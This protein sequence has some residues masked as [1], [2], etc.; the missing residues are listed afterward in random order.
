MTTPRPA[1]GMAGG[2]GGASGGRVLMLAPDDS[3]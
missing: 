1:F 2:C 3:V